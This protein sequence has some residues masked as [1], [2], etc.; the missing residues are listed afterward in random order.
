MKMQ[1]PEG[2]ASGCTVAG[3]KTYDP[4]ENDQVEVHD[5]DHIAVLKKHGY[6]PVNGLLGTKAKKPKP[7]VEEDDEEDEDDK[8]SGMTKGECKDWLEERDIDIPS[9]VKKLA[10]LQ[11]LCRENKDAAKAD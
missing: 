3:G 7:V 10:D 1:A 6:T 11:A 5:A 9:G 2:Y 8:F 4:D